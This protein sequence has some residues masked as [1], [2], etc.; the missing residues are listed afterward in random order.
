MPYAK[1]S[2]KNPPTIEWAEKK[3]PWYSEIEKDS[4]SKERIDLTL[5]CL[6]MVEK[7][8]EWPLKRLARLI[9]YATVDEVRH[10]WQ[11]EV[12]VLNGLKK[13]PK[14]SGSLETYIKFFGKQEGTKRFDE[15]Q[16]TTSD[17]G[18][19]RTIRFW[20][21][22]GFTEQEAIEKVSEFQSMSGKIRW[23]RLREECADLSEYAKTLM[24]QCKEYVGYSG[25]ADSEIERIRLKFID[26]TMANTP[27]RY[28]KKYG[29][30]KGKEILKEINEK[31]AKSIQLA[32]LSKPYRNLSAS[33]ESLEVFN[34]LMDY[35]KAQLDI[36]EFWIGTPDNNGERWLRDIELKLLYFYD[37]TLLKQKIII[38]FNGI[39]Y[40]PKPDYTWTEGSPW[41]LCPVTIR[42][43]DL[44]KIK[45]AE[46][47]GFSVLEIWS[48]E[49]AETN[50]EICKRFIHEKI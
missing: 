24:P 3:K 46:S 2:D 14:G 21:R 40:H 45:L 27:T 10:Y 19:P 7:M 30:Q 44:R 25:I 36:D 47:K 23:D 11:D 16:K 50:L 38:E 6:Q 43:K 4:L 34:P 42:E 5:E 35:L 9:K 22:K 26:E 39:K 31:R 1:F 33:K 8:D 41:N 49:D 15:Q 32:K 20:T 18:G 29:E 12:E 17:R 48:D 37:F 28:I 13:R